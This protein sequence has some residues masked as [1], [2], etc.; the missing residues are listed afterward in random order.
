MTIKYLKR[1]NLPDLAYCLTLS[2]GDNAKIP[3]VFL[4]GFRSDMQGTK[5]LYL[6]KYCQKFDHPYLRFD[7]S[8]H[9]QSEGAFKDFCISDWVQ[10]TKD[11]IHHHFDRPVLIIGSSMGG[12]IGLILAQ[13][14]PQ[15]LAGFI[16]LAAA[17][18]FTQWIEEGIN[19]DQKQ[20]LL[21]QGYFDMDNDY[22]DAYQITSKLLEDGHRNKILNQ[23]INASFPV[24][25]IQ[26][27]KDTDVPWH[28]AEAI[29]QII[30]P[31]SVKITYIEEGD[32]R[33]SSSK[34]LEILGD[35]VKTII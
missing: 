7:Y 29:K 5:A 31:P 12:W 16:G 33:L 17:P 30:S 19:A 10:D 9:G 15:L 26:G 35:V 1:Q 24:H 4:G 23:E 20:T 25:L 27:K 18:D 21:Q 8:G 2:K 14:A 11:I 28:T 6:E 13:K 34:E 32:H 22:G 3:I